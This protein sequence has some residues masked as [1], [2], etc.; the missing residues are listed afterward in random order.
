MAEVIELSRVGLHDRV[1][2]RLQAMLIEGIIPPGTKLNERE[3]CEKLNVSRTPLREAIKLLGTSGMVELLPNR[4][5][6]AVELSEEDVINSFEVLATLEGMSGELAAQ[7]IGDDRR[8]E[9][10]ALHYE[11]LAYFT[12]NDLSG[13]YRI[14]TQIHQALI[15]AAG[16]PVLTAAHEM[17]NARLQSLRFR[18]NQNRTQWQQAVK[19]HSMMIEALD[20]RDAGGLKAILTGHLLNKRDSILEFMRKGSFRDDAHSRN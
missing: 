13:Y 12:R 14:N 11:M 16:N 4:G 17:T 20:A 1:L 3:L 8:N 15:E 5:A 19:E 6:V 18:T 10:R 9:I 7:R 2:V